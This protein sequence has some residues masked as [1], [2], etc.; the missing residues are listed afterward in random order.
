MSASDRLRDELGDQ[1]EAA[2]SDATSGPPR[3][4]PARARS[5][6]RST[7]DAVNAIDTRSVLAWLEI[8]VEERGEKTLATCPGC[9]E[10]GALVCRDGGLKCL[11]D[12]CNAAG[13][14]SC[15]G[16]RSNVDL[17]MT[18][19]GYT[20]PA[21]AAREL[22]DHFGVDQPPHAHQ[23]QADHG[24]PWNIADA[25][26]VFLS[27]VPDTSWIIRDL[28]LGPGRPCMFWGA[29]SSGK[30]SV[31][32]EAGIAVATG[33]TALGR[34]GARHGRVLHLSYDVGRAAVFF[35]YRQLANGRGLT[36]AELRD[37]LV[38][39]IFPRVYLNSEGAEERLLERCRG[40]DFVILDSFRDAIPGEKEDDSAVVRFL[41]IL[42]RISD[43]LDT[44][45]LVLHHTRKSDDSIS[46]LSGR[47]SIAIAAAAGT[48]WG[49]EGNGTGP[50][51]MRCIRRHD[52]SLDRPMDPFSVHR[53]VVGGVEEGFVARGRSAF[54]LQARRQ[55]EREA[56][57]DAVEQNSRTNA[58]A[59]ARIA[60]VVRLKPGSSQN[61][62][63]TALRGTKLATGGDAG[64]RRLI[65]TAIEHRDIHARRGPRNSLLHY[66]GPGQDEQTTEA[67]EPAAE[68]GQPGSST[69][70]A[71]AP[72]K[73]GG[74]VPRSHGRST[75]SERCNS[76]RDGSAA[77]AAE[78]NAEV[79]DRSKGD[80]PN[81]SS[82]E[83]TGQ[84]ASEDEEET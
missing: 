27:D 41:R 14:R 34:F 68:A 25:D 29:P 84:S 13:P 77:V 30:T 71:A 11:H 32:Q 80:E 54:Q 75:T 36:M 8:A 69:V 6:R 76:A 58:A 15:P 50:R 3:D 73:G 10:A 9:S 64:I 48:I 1:A 43:A 12:R 78:V 66:A 31:A 37:R 39:G 42:A 33:S 59:I 67:R 63:V 18:A 53:V 7:W 40:F 44:T 16:F 74:G 20:T 45:F 56:F 23:E 17:V 72:P 83:V 52:A 82:A 19:R 47:G 21:Q 55:D 70:A 24:D 4:G 62:L 60:E 65:A 38:V 51:D 81:L 57:F 5:S 46:L 61:Y 2:P 79:V 26:E 35:R 28:E 49:I 22:A